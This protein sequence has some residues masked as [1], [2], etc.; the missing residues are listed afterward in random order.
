MDFFNYSNQALHAENVA[1]SDIA[2][3]YGTPCYVYSRAT[4][5]R[6]YKAYADEQSWRDQ[7]NYASAE[8]QARNNKQGLWRAARPQ[9][10]WDYRKR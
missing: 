3:Q 5:E 1:L 4:L 10:P 9:A 7:R 2:N 8:K 6:H